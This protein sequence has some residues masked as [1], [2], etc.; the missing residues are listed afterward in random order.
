MRKNE[1]ISG[2]LRET[3]HAKI[4]LF[5]HVLGRQEDGYHLLESLV[6]FAD[7]HDALTLEVGERLSLRIEGPFAAGLIAEDDNLILRA[8][9]L[10]A[11]A[12]DVSEAGH[13]MLEKNL[14]VASGIGG[15]SADAAAALR[16][17][18]RA[19]DVALDDPRLVTIA[20]ALGADVPV[21]LFQKP[22]LM[23]GIGH[24]LGPVLQAQALPA[25]LVNPGVG[26]ET[27]AVFTRLGLKP[28]ER[29]SP[30]HAA[31][32]GDLLSGTR[33]DLEAPAMAVAP[34]IGETLARMRAHPGC[35][36]A[37]MSGSGATCFALFD[38]ED[39]AQDAA[40]RLALTH[41]NWWIR[42]TRI[43]LPER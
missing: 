2:M 3:A 26:V 36:I 11:E 25:V 1:D 39:Q 14:P 19:Q 43:T 20:R 22:R 42:P 34:I 23:R 21:C 37:R 27:R 15:G 17:L 10:F 29:F 35:R 16:L 38:S 24:D 18:V 7:A 4:N 31:L 9:R 30:S 13:F 28:G 32:Q 5:L 41:P 40:S 33:N 6:G 8:A 12:F